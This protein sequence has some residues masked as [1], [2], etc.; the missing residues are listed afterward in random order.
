MKAGRR[1]EGYSECMCVCEGERG[2]APMKKKKH[3][4]QSVDSS[5]SYNSLTFSVS[6]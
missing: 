6:T 3:K 2:G 4:G 1:R 5:S